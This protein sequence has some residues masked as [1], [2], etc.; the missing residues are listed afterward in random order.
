[1]PNFSLNNR[2]KDAVRLYENPESVLADTA[3]A[4]EVVVGPDGLAEIKSYYE[5]VELAK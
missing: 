3:N 1:M 5:C 2:K 4:G